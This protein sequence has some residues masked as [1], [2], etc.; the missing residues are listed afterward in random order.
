MDYTNGIYIYLRIDPYFIFLVYFTGPDHGNC[1]DGGICD[2]SDDWSGEYC[3]IACYNGTNVD[4]SCVCHQPCIT[5]I[6]CHLECTAHGKCDDNGE[7][8]CD[9][10]GTYTGDRCDEPSCPGWPVACQGHGT[11]N[12]VTGECE[13]D[14]YWTGSACEKADCA[15]T[16][17]CNGVNATCG[18]PPEGG[19][20]RCLDCQYP[21]TGDSCE[22]KC[23]HGTS[24]RAFDGVWKCSCDF[25]YS[26]VECDSLCSGQG[27]CQNNTCDCG[28]N[29]YRG[30]WCQIRGCPGYNIDCSGNGDC[31]SATGQCVCNEGF[32]GVGCHIPSCPQDCNSVGSCILDDDNVPTCSCHSNYFGYAC[33]YDCEHGTVVNGTCECD[34]CY[35]DYTCSLPCSGTGNCTNGACDCGFNGG[36]GDYCEKPGC[37]GHGTDCSGNG[38]CNVGTGNC[39]CY[40]GWKGDGCEESDCL[41]NCNFRGYCNVSLARPRCTSCET[42]WMGESCSKVCNGNQVPMDSGNCVCG[43]K[44]ASGD[45]CEVVCSGSGTCNN[46]TCVC[47]SGYWGDLC[48]D[49]LCLGIGELCTGHGDCNTVT[50]ECFCKPGWYGEDCSAPDCPGDPDCN[51]RGNCSADTTYPTCQCNDDWTGYS[52]ELPCVYGTPQA[53][54]TCVCEPC[55]AGTGCDSL[56]GGHGACND[57]NCT[58]DTAWWGKILL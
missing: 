50:R 55:Y 20:P 43:S 52:C 1:T 13:C 18:V 31:N 33:Q 44:C 9:F 58:C 11:C 2:C 5:G 35:N 29:G 12:S 32:K 47:N 46:E 23:V 38:E 57:G 10:Y 34:N 19:N 26:G 27:T 30:D 15:G 37:A 17:D 53:D 45:S 42:G 39:I 24:V 48:E 51:D 16:P 41:D 28:F 4:G 25:C 14:L 21:Y 49:H 7:C 36:R 22:Y 40:E 6:S 56:C 3:H 54:F 8:A